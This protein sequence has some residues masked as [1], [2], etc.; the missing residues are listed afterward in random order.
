VLQSQRQSLAV[1]DFATGTTAATL[2]QQQLQQQ[3]GAL[4]SDE[5]PVLRALAYKVRDMLQDPE[6]T[7]LFVP[8]AQRLA[9]LGREIAAQLVERQ[10]VRVVKS[11][12]ALVGSP[13]V[14]SSS[15]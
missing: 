5:F 4:L 10:A 11:A 14:S 8:I 15:T 6:Q 12:I 1:T 3:E 13:R 2:Q 7:A 9:G